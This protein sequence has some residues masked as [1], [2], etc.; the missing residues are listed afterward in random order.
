MIR[1]LIIDVSPFLLL[2]LV[3][4]FCIV[5]ASMITVSLN[6]N[7]LSLFIN[8]LG[9]YNRVTIRNTF[10]EK[11]KE[12]YRRSNKINKIFYALIASVLAVYVLMKA[13]G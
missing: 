3:V 4:L 7:F 6:A 12:Y 8:S 2:A 11:L 9:F 13:I 5:K 10:H 1:H